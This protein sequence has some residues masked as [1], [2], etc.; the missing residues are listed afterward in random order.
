VTTGTNYTFENC[1]FSGDTSTSIVANII[2][3]S[4]CNF[5][6]SSSLTSSLTLTL[7]ASQELYYEGNRSASGRF[8][9]TT[10]SSTNVISNNR[11]NGLVRTGTGDQSFLIVRGGNFT[12][13]NSN[14]FK[15]VG[16]YAG[17]GIAYF[18]NMVGLGGG[19]TGFASETNTF[20]TDSG[21]GSDWS[22]YLAS[23]YSTTG[24]FARV[25]NNAFTSSVQEVGTFI[26]FSNGNYLGSSYIKTFVGIFPNNT[27]PAVFWSLSDYIDTPYLDQAPTATLSGG[28]M[29]YELK[30][31]DLQTGA[32]R[33][34]NIGL[35]ANCETEI[36]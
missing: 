26:D 31:L 6:M 2:E 35:S 32:P 5:T 22:S 15:G 34:L 16:I 7:T 12:A 8:D 30:L 25:R 9:F 33:R 19:I 3:V 36:T 10:G 1:E 14:A 4:R 23:G 11:F 18:I 24:H 27:Y 20:T 29:S 28:M 13:I 21:L 17:G